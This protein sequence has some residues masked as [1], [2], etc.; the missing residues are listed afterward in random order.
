MSIDLRANQN[1]AAFVQ[2]ALR[3]FGL[4]SSIGEA[5][6]GLAKTIRDHVHFERLLT[7]T[8]GADRQELYDSVVPHLRFSAKPLDVYISDAKHRAE[9]ERWP[10]LG[11]DGQLH[12]FKPAADVKSI[13]KAA[14]DAIV[15]DLAARTLTLVC[16]KC[17][18][19][20]TFVGIEGETPVQVVMKAREAG[21]IYDYLSTPTREICPKC[22]SSLRP[23]A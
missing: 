19:I 3:H 10:T 5:I 22:P 14:E 12:P 13:E 6:A 9:R 4:P 7:E 18:R 1:E 15:A 8:D 2:K 17:T 16:S 11:A 20:G 21:W 23:N